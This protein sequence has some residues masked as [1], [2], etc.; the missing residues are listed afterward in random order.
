M[1][2]EYTAV[3]SMQPTSQTGTMEHA[4]PMFKELLKRYR[5]K[6]DGKM[7]QHI[8]YFRDGTSESEFVHIRDKE[9]RPLKE[10]T[11]EFGT[12]ITLII[13]VKRHHTRFMAEGQFATKLG[14]VLSSCT[15]C[16]C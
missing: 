1:L 12:K 8:I 7:P 14:Y 3:A 11:Q 9:G 4:A 2:Q 13:A 10:L 5:E 16:S 15:T 6:N